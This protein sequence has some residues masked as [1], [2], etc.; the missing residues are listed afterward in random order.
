MLARSYSYTL[1]GLDAVPVDIEVDVATGLPNLTIVGLPDQAVREA[2]ERLRSA[3]LNSQFELPS[4][5]L[6]IN[7]APADVKKEGGA[8]DLPMALGILAA[9]GQ[10]DPAKVAEVVAVGELALDGRL[11]S[12][13]GILPM[14]MAAKTGRY[15]TCLV[16]ATNAAEAAVVEGLHVIG[17]ESLGQAAA[18]LA[19]TE[20]IAPWSTNGHARP[21]SRNRHPLDDFA[22]VKG[23]ALAKRALEVAVAGAHH[24]L[25]IGPPGS[26]K[27]ML[28]QRLPAILPDLSLE[29]ALE[30]TKIHSI[31][32]LLSAK[33]PLITQRPFRAPHHTSSAV[34]LIGGGP[35]PHPGE[36]SLAHHGVLFLDELPEFH[37]DVLESL[38][39]PLEEGLVRVARAKRTLTF[40]ARFL[41]VAA[42]NPC[43]CGYLTD[44]KRRCR[45]SSTQIQR[46]LAKISGPLLDRIDLH[47]D[48]PAVPF[49][50]LTQAQD[51]EPSAAIKARVLKARERQRKR[52]AKEGVFANAQMR[53]RQIQKHCAMTDGAKTLLK[54]AMEEL[55]LSARAYDKVLKVARTI[56]DLAGMEE[57][58]P[59]HIAESIQY[60]SLDRQLWA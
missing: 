4:Q 16:P 35:A 48:V 24:V 44:P 51:G 15:R 53:H 32:G 12:T 11:R 10:V 17:V 1:V 60:R 37:R 23:Q 14:A 29:E 39:Q 31:M 52:F 55:G 40:P 25:L 5:R 54:Q 21:T 46:Y 30:T 18:Y 33:Q 49:H 22:D 26:G 45:C 36:I 57:I 50:A 9:S 38:R 34:A 19:G 7:L 47:I 20:L 56:A 43:Q 8:F 27:S 41:L 13:P 3:I 6:T 2:R 59:E 58:L 28:A 42:M